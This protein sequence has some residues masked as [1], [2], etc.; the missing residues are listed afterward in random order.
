MKHLALIINLFAI[1]LFIPGIFFPMFS[2]SM[3][4][5]ASAAGANLTSQVIDKE[6][7]LL[8][9]VEELWRDER[10]LVASLIFI[11]SIVIPVIK[12]VMLTLSYFIKKVSIKLKLSGFVSA[13]GKWSMA[14]VFVVAV[15][16]AVLSTNHADTE[17]QQ[18]LVI[19]GLKLDLMLSSST[20]SAVGPGFYYF[21]AYCL[22]SLIGSQIT[23]WANKTANN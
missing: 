18:Q 15:L 22:V 10:L 1:A 7:S 13:I 21:T 17:S 16:L 9:T 6:L 12:T 2:L 3:D 20:L 14:D 11:F 4:M 5:S 19:F 8:G 23:H